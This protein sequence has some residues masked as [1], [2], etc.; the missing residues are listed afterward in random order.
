GAR[1][2][3]REL[4]VVGRL[5]RH[6]VKDAAVGELAQSPGVE[7]LDLVA[8][9]A[10]DA[11]PKAVADHLAEHRALRAHEPF[12]KVFAGKTESDA[13]LAARLLLEQL[14]VEARELAR[15][16]GC[17]GEAARDAVLG[18]AIEPDLAAFGIE[19]DAA[20][21]LDERQ[22]RGDVVFVDGVDRDRG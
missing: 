9:L 21:R 8:R 6:Q 10:L 20:G 4:A 16:L 19:H 22:A 13:R 7:A 1:E 5:A 17:A 14:P 11:R 12:G 15:R 18:A 2:R 3:E